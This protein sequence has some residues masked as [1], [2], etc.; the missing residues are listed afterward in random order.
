MFI[1]LQDSIKCLRDLRDFCFKT[2]SE[3]DDLE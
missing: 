2:Y 1:L 3:F